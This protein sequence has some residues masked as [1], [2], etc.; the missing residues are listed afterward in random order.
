MLVCSKLLCVPVV[1]VTCPNCTTKLYQVKV[2][3]RPYIKGS[4]P[5]C[6]DG[7]KL[8]DGKC[9]AT[10]N[11]T[12]KYSCNAIVYNGSD[13]KGSYNSSTKK[14]D[15]SV[16]S[17]CPSGYT[18]S[19]DGKSCTKETTTT[20]Y[21][22]VYSNVTYYRYRTLSCSSDTYEYAWSKSKSDA[23]LM[24]RGYYLTGKQREVK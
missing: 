9:Y 21:E 16:S 11:K 15:Y 1:S 8:I 24:S 12:T 17:V 4:D 5:Y 18:K 22:P 3:T 7:Y 13:V 14:C 19:A 2:C 20:T 10:T 23:T 6:K